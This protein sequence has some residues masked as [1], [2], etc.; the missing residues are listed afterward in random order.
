MT[1]LA[2]KLRTRRPHLAGTLSAEF[3]SLSTIQKL[4]VANFSR[5]ERMGLAA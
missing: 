4:T 3:L 5:E 1:P 2:E